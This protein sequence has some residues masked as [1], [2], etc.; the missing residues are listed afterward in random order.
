MDILEK[1]LLAINVKSHQVRNTMIKTR[2]MRV[3]SK[4]SRFNAN[5]TYIQLIVGSEDNQNWYRN[6]RKVLPIFCF[7]SSVR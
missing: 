4:V 5:E 2:S 3:L 1:V 6:R 7:M